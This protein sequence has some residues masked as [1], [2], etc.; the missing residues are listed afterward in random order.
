MKKEFNIRKFCVNYNVFIIFS[1]L[2]IACTL[3]SESFLLPINLFNIGLQQAA[4][5]FVAIGV[6]FP[7][8]MGGIDLSVGSVMALASSGVL[9]VMNKTDIGL[10]LGLALAVLIGLACGLLNGFLVA[11]CNMPGFV[12][13]LATLTTLK[14]FAYL[15]TNG[16]TIKV[17]GN[18]LLDLCKRDYGYPT[19]IITAVVIVLFILMQHYT[20]FGRLILATGSNRTAVELAGIRV[21]R[22]ILSAYVISG[23]M[24][25]LA[26]MWLAA[27]TST[28]N[29]VL[30]QGAEL[31]AVAACVLGGTSLS[32]GRGSALKTFVGALCLAMI[33]NIMNLM[34]VGAYIQNIVQGI[35]IVFAVLMYGI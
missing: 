1:V 11:Y 31:N 16:N 14:G 19:I 18:V 24:A 27:R 3:L 29:A 30:G 12:A 6:M 7:I 23:V 5:I 25:A 21:K 13:T 15:I 2:F 32:G 20:V 26:G 10:G 17:T 9:A 8:I 4:P 35:I 33:G 22:Y 34:G 28:S